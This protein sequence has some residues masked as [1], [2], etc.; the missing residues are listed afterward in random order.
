MVFSS[1]SVTQ[2]TSGQQ[3]LAVGEIR[4]LVA[5]HLHVD[6]GRV[7]DEAHFRHDLGADW[8]DRL[9]LLLLIEDQFADVEI[10]DDDAHQIEVVGDLMRYVEGARSRRGVL[11]AMS[12]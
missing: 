1:L 11:T 5:R 10:T 7:T 12:L 8:L 4:A 2:P 6:V 9:E 3:G